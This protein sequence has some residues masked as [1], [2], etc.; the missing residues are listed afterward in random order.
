MPAELAE[1]ARAA[2]G[3]V[4]VL[5][6]IEV[7][8]ELWGRALLAAAPLRFGA[9]IKGKVLDSLAA[10]IPCLCTAIAAEG[11]HLPEALAGLV[12]DD[13]AAMARE[14]SAGCTMTPPRWTGWARPG[15]NIS[16]STTAPR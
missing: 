11:L 15:G 5:G 14:M 4:E 3:P 8:A 12:Q 10:G 6:R 2:R 9:G 16:A 13:P 7:L 1:A